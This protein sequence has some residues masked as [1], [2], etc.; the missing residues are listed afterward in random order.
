MKRQSL[1]PRVASLVAIMIAVVYVLTRLVQ[2][3]IGSQG[4]IHLGD[5]A[6]YFT[7]FAFGP[8]VA[9]VAG[10]LGTSL[11]DATT[12]YAQWA[13]FSLLVHGIQ[14]YVA[15]LLTQRIPGL[16]GQLIAVSSGGLILIIGYFAAGVLLTG[17]GEA[18]TGILPNT[19]QALSGGIVGI[20]LFAAVL[21]AYPPLAQWGASRHWTE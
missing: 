18:V 14:G 19:L 12:G 10:G 11:V 1:D 21:R 8:W 7:A 15:G 2:I 6:I 4:F 3:P 13:I 9:A 20:P 5:A 16:Y 17:V